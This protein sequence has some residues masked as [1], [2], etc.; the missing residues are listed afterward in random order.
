MTSG[1]ARA[2]V[3]S[4]SISNENVRWKGKSKQWQKIS[5]KGKNG[6]MG[7]C[8]SLMP[9]LSE[10]PHLACFESK[11]GENSATIEREEPFSARN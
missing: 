4:V 11:Q 5:S 6:R 10:Q 7:R 8:F 2:A 3:L 9:G 1:R